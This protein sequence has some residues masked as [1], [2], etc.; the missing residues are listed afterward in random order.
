MTF[1]LCF[2]VL[3]TAVEASNVENSVM[4][5][6]AIGMAVFLAH[7]ILIPIDGC[8]I[9]PTRSFGPAFIAA[10]YRNSGK[11]D[12]W[13]TFSDMWIFWAG[14]LSGAIIAA[15]AYAAFNV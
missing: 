5:C 11:E 6:F 7:S 2:T 3:E 14:P 12:A 13:S 4:A 1:I 8:S 15:G 9:N 10:V